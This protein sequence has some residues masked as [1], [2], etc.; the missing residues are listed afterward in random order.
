ME[1]NYNDDPKVVFSFAGE[2]GLEVPITKMIEDESFQELLRAAFGDAIPIMAEIAERRQY[3]HAALQ[4]SIF[5]GRTYGEIIAESI[6]DD[7]K[8]TDGNLLEKLLEECR[9]KSAGDTS[10]KI[11]G[12]RIDKIEFPIDKINAN[13]WRLLETADGDGQ[14]TLGFNMANPADKKKGREILATYSINFDALAEN[15]KLSK[16]LN[17]FDKRV[18][19]AV[20]AVFSAGNRLMT[21][22]QIHAA[23][24]GTT[25]P[26][27]NQIERIND[28]L[29]KMRGAVISIDNKKE[30]DVYKNVPYYTYDGSLLPFVRVTART[31]GQITDMAIKPLEE[32]PLMTF[33]KQRRQVT[34]IDIKLLQSPASKTDAN[35]AIEDYLLERLSRAKYKQQ[36][37]CRILIST[38]YEKLSITTKDQ[39]KRAPGKIKSYLDHY[40]TCAF[41]KS[42]KIGPERIDI[43]F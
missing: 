24:G 43:F 27:R 5:G 1:E 31:R 21:V 38:L 26:A 29:T 7:G 11:K 33:A 15:V 22:E 32:P 41:I 9:K 17:A 3:L 12:A 40:V 6:S 42:Y 36:S 2:D 25:R 28:S 19:I 35:L 13:V 8:L 20:S 39:K 14:L 4:S 30:S 34:T 10:P 16:H 37:S 18:Y 23:M